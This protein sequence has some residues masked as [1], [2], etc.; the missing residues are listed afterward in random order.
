M[1]L[2]FQDRGPRVGR[3]VF[4]APN[5][6]VIGRVALGDSSSVWFGSVLRGDV[7]S[8]T[9]GAETNIQ[10]LTVVHAD[11]DT[12]TRVGNRVTVGHRA[13][14][15]GCIVEDECIV[16]MGAIIQNRARISSH[17]IVASGSVVREGFEALPGVLLAG[18]PARVKRELTDTEID[19]INE[20]AETYMGRARLYLADI[21]PE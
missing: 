20:L 7:D 2:R 19:Y 18:V 4:I 10:D 3:R 14:L 21:R 1:L 15:H 12:P 8:I 16:G 5:A 17:T 6:M 13:I 11:A 9:I